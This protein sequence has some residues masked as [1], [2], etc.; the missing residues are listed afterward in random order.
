MAKLV[1][2]F[3]LHGLSLLELIIVLSI[4]SLL[5]SFALPNFAETISHKRSDIAASRLKQTIEF[6][7]IT[8][9][10]RNTLVT[11]CRSTHGDECGGSWGQGVLV[12]SDHNGDREIDDTD[13]IV[14]YTRFHDYEGT[15]TWR[16]FQNR[17]Y[18]QITP[19]GFTKYQNGNFTFCPPNGDAKFARQLIVNR[20]ART[21]F[22]LDKDQDG[23]RE[24][25]R[26]QPL[27]CN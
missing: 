9:I 14:R 2:G 23:V 5:L 25:S 20:S 8:A 3:L 15:V 7:R 17:Q 1:Y 6:A 24:N 26:G 21:R 18:L 12:F 22:A 19:L 11:I 13:E 16:A 4:C 27:N 10:T